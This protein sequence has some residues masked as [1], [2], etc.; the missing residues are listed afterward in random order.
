MAEFGCKLSD[1]A[2]L[3]GRRLHY[4]VVCP[5]FCPLTLLSSFVARCCSVESLPPIKEGLCNSVE[6]VVM[7]GLYGHYSVMQAGWNVVN[8]SS[9]ACFFCGGRR[10][11]LRTPVLQVL[12]PR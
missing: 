10:M 8:C 1:N 5:G 7:G 3:S 11:C 4:K 6:R 9:S 12:P 2:E